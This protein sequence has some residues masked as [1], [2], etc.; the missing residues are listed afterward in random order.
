[1]PYL[2]LAPDNF[3][4]Y[5]TLLGFSS[6]Y[7]SFHLERQGIEQASLHVREFYVTLLLLHGYIKRG[8][9]EASKRDLDLAFDYWNDYKQTRKVSYAEEEEPNEPL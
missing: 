3:M 2:L 5:L 1:M 8:G 6:H 9:Q 4:T 7:G